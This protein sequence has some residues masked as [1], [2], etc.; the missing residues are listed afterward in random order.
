ML[1]NYNE[2][3]ESRGQGRINDDYFCNPYFFYLEARIPNISFHK[4]LTLVKDK[5]YEAKVENFDLIIF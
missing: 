3:V 4:R 2:F 5:I 1:A